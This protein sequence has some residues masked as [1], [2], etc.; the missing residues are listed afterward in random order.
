MCIIKIDLLAFCEN[1]TYALEEYKYFW[2]HSWLFLWFFKATVQIVIEKT[3]E[4]NALLQVEAISVN[5]KLLLNDLTV[6]IIIFNLLLSN[7]SLLLH[8]EL[9]WNCDIFLYLLCILTKLQIKVFFY[10]HSEKK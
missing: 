4:K 8:I 6:C 3:M 1:K 9:R 7:I 10:S 5:K 2:Q